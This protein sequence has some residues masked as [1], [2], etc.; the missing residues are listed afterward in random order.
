ML[1]YH[2]LDT[3]FLNMVATLSSKM[4][5]QIYQTAEHHIPEDSNIDAHHGDSLKFH[6]AKLLLVF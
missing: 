6:K 2:M 5:V 3:C 4:L 1:P